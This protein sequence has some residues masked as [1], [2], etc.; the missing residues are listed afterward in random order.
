[1]VVADAYDSL[2]LQVHMS[3]AEPTVS[4][5]NATAG[6]VAAVL[7][8]TVKAVAGQMASHAALRYTFVVE[9]PTALVYHSLARCTSFEEIR[10]RCSMFR[11]R[12]ALLLVNSCS[13]VGSVSDV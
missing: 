8:L 11:K 9:P 10:G 2:E 3:H 13:A 5:C 12:T 4:M 1:M 6:S 7:H